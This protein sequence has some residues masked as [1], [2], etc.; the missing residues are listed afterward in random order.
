MGEPAPLRARRAA[1]RARARRAP[2]GARRSGARARRTPSAV[3]KSAP[4]PSLASCTA[5]TAPP[6]PG[7]LPALGDVHDLAGRRQP[8]HAGELHPLDVPDDGDPRHGAQ[9]RR[10][11]LRASRPR[12]PR[13]ALKPSRS[14]ARVGRGEHVAHVAAAP[15]PGDLRLGGRRRTRGR[16]PAPCR[17][18]VRGV[19]L[20]TLNAPVTGSSA[21]SASTFARATSRTW[22]K[23]RRMPPSSKTWAPARGERGAED[24]RHA[25]VGRVARHPRA[26]DVVVAQ[27]GDGHAGLARERGAQVLLGD[28]RRRVDVARIQRRASSGTVRGSSGRPQTGHGGS[29]SPASSASARARAGPHDAVLGAGVAALAVDDHARGEHDPPAE[30]ALRERPQQLRGGEVVVPDVVGDVARC[31]RRGPTIAAWWQTAVTPST[32]RA[33]TASGRA[34]RPRRAR[35][36]GRC[37]PAARGAPRAAARRR[38]GPAR[39]ARAA[40]RRCGSR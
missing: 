13:R 21:V 5:A 32:A 40:R 15:L 24:A 6:P 11:E 19:P 39:R 7:L 16:A 22:T 9:R 10:G 29:K 8:R 23:S 2:R 30:A 3:K 28:L 34:G 33:A 4:P 27:R 31:R 36:A 1:P 17:A 37:S 12:S 26:V 20:A 25:R 18:R 35:P 14:A 38:S